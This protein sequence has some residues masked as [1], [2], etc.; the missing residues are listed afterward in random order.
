VT[1]LT[2][3]E[4]ARRLVNRAATYER[5][6]ARGVPATIVGH[7]R[8]LVAETA[9]QIRAL[10]IP[11]APVLTGEVDLLSSLLGEVVPDA[12][13]LNRHYHQHG[14]EFKTCSRDECVAARGGGGPDDEPGHGY[15]EAGDYG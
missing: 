15:W 9:D 10:G 3:L 13:V 11:E 14:G 12:Q 8:R 7:Q 4:L 5:M 6:V 2:E 1:E